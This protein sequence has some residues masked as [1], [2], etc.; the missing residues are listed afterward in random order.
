MREQI[1]NLKVAKLAN[2]AGFDWEVNHYYGD[3]E[4]K[5][6]PIYYNWNSKEE[7]KLW[8]I[9]LNSAASQSSLQ[10]WFRKKHNMEVLVTCN[11]SG[12]FWEINKAYPNNGGTFIAWS[13]DNGPNDAGHW[14]TYEEALD[15]GLEHA[16]KL[17]NLKD[18]Q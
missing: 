5:S 17:L 3:D 13:G 11:A 4:L 9:Q 6:M 12:W 8:H 7:Q 2:K 10:K 16:L 14:E 15:D 18:K 1:V